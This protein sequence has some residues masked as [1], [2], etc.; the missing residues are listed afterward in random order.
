MANK[1]T[2]KGG[3]KK[4]KLLRKF[5]ILIGLVIIVSLLSLGAY[6]A[7]Q[8]YFFKECKEYELISNDLS[9]NYIKGTQESTGT[10]FNIPASSCA[11]DTKK[12][13]MTYEDKGFY[14]QKESCKTGERDSKR[15]YIK[16]SYERCA[17]GCFNGECMNKCKDP[18]KDNIFKKG[19]SYGI[20][21]SSILTAPLTAKA[22]NHEDYCINTL[23][24]D[25]VKR[26]CNQNNYLGTTTIKCDTICFDGAC[27]KNNFRHCE[28]T[29]LEDQGKIPGLVQYYNPTTN[30]A[31][32]KIDYC[33]NKKTITEYFCGKDK[34]A[35]K[36]ILT[37][38]FDCSNGQCLQK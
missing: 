33:N 20:D 8:K 24:K 32:T 37:C 38:R 3:K 22:S 1:K 6:K 28:D 29:D 16:T 14:L 10:Y 19:I 23:S 2:K 7:S 26:T 34:L 30:E 31:E 13:L 27:Q 15:T 25:L 5:D 21:V 11:Q 17:F 35:H 9:Y 4:I 18:D 12:D 36:L